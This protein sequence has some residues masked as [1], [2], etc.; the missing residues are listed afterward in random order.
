M[1]RAFS[2]EN[3]LLKIPPQET[4]SEQRGGV[5]IDPFLAESFGKNR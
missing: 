2:P 5:V 1:I 3:G 4:E